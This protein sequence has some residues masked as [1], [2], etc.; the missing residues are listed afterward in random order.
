MSLFIALIVATLF[1]IALSALSTKAL[2]ALVPRNQK[3][4]AQDALAA[5]AALESA[6]A[7]EGAPAE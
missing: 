2:L 1:A 4:A 3:R 7:A 5:A 6:R